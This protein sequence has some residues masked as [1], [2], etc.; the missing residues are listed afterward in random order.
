[1]Q[2]FGASGVRDHEEHAGQAKHMIGVH[3]RETN[4]PQL[5]KTPAQRFPGNLRSLTTIQQCEG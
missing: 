2:R 5:A 4:S 3:V 1:M